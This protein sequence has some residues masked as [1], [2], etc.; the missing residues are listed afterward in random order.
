M[1][2]FPEMEVT[3]GGI[4]LRHRRAIGNW[5]LGFGHGLFE[6]LVGCSGGRFGW[7]AAGYATM[8]FWVSSGLGV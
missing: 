2:P 8:G 4:A 5:E 7:E 1:L 6:V 3:L